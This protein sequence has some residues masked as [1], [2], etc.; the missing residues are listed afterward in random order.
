M[1][2]KRI[3]IT[4][5][6]GLLGQALVERLAA[7]VYCDVLATGLD[8]APRQAAGVSFGYARLDICDAQDAR[9][10]IEDFA[11]HWV[12]NCAALTQ[13]DQC[14]KDRELCW[15]INVEGVDSLARI[16][17][18]FGAQLL[19]IS[20]D[21]VFEGTQDMYSESDRPKPLSFYGRSKLAGENAAREAGV[22][23]WAVVRTSVVYGTAVGRP[24]A[25]FV[26]W[27]LGRLVAD[28]PINVFTDQWRTPTYSYDLAAGIE[29]LIHKGVSGVYNLTGR[30]YVTMFSFAQT[31]AEVFEFDTGLVLPASGS[32][33]VQL[34]PR[35][36]RSGLV[37][38]KA[39][40][41]IGY[42]PMGLR[43]ALLHLK[44]RHRN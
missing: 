36:K 18:T 20:T 41:E 29:G 31:I 13:V 3:L 27:V 8:P 22:D 10:V 44:Q 21:F 9:R 25:D 35:P 42:R 32:T 4:G 11:P 30:D 33:L 14:Q 17:R 2:F 39:E 5:A 12:I 37:I 34:A 24:G 43:D 26:E 28:E 1:P 15:R 16:C 40:T 38:L 7:N 23:Q 6:N 19:Q